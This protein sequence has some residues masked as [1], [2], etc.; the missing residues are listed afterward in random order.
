MSPSLPPPPPPPPGK[1]NR[2]RGSPPPNLS[3]FKSDD[4]KTW[5]GHT[6]CRNLFK[7][8]K[9]MIMSLSFECYDV[10]TIFEVS[11]QLE[12]GRSLLFLCFPIDSAKLSCRVVIVGP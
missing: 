5:Y 1:F 4:D 7:L 8:V 10:I 11:Y 3:I 6:I 12:S 2:T 9:K